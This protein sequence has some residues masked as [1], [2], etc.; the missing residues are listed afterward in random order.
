MHT[1]SDADRFLRE[2]LLERF[3]LDD[4]PLLDATAQQLAGVDPA[5][6]GTGRSAFA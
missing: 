5:V 4:S 2:L 1:P 3:W 6:D